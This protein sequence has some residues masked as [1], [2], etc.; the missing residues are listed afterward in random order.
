MRAEFDRHKCFGRKRALEQAGLIRREA[1]LRIVAGVSHDKDN[2]F[3]PFPHQ[4]ESALDEEGANSFALVCGEDGDRRQGDSR[5][6]F[7]RIANPHPAEH[8]VTDHAALNFSHERNERMFTGAQ[9]IDQVGFLRAS[10]SC[11]VDG[12]NGGAFA[13]TPGIFH[14]DADERIHRR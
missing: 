12:A 14:S 10:E 9:A 3:A 5:Y 13:G 2:L 6:E 4:L 8:D 7:A 11:G 1:E